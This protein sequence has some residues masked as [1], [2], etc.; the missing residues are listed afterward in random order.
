MFYYKIKCSFSILKQYEK[1]LQAEFGDIITT[2][3]QTINEEGEEELEKVAQD[4]PV[5]RI[6]DTLL[7][8]AILEQ[9]SDIHIEPTEKE[10]V[11]RYRID[12][13]LHDAMNLPK[14]LCKVLW[15]V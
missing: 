12:G 15:L 11:V 4:I 14:K 1:S 5:I 6:V 7:K 3:S 8:H 13:I 10:V 2:D 9:A